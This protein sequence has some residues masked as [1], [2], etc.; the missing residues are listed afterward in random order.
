[1]KIWLTE[2]GEPLPIDVGSRPMRCGVL[3]QTLAAREHDVTWWAS[4]F[5][6]VR[7][8][9]RRPAA[10]T[11]SAGSRLHLELL[12]GPAYRRNVSVARIRHQRAMAHQF[13]ARAEALSPPD[14]LYCCVPTLEVTEAALRYA[15]PRGIPVV[16]DVRDMWP[17]IFVATLSRPLRAPARLLLHSEFG[18]ARRIFRSAAAILAVSEGY[19]EWAL[20]YAARPRRS[21]DAVFPH[22]YPRTSVDA[23]TAARARGQLQSLGVDGRRVICAFVGTF[24]L[25]YDLGTVIEAARLLQRTGYDDVQFVLAG[26]GER[27]PDW[28]AQAAGLSNVIFTG[29]IS[30]EAIAALLGMARF[31]LAAYAA[32]APQ[33]LPNKLG[34]YLSAGIPVLSSLRGETQHLLHEAGCGAS[35][36]AGDAPTL[37][38]LLKQLTANETARAEMGRRALERYNAEFSAQQVYGRLADH[39]EHFSSVAR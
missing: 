23:A 28:Q 2:I 31:G 8:T 37:A 10:E 30:A 27:R 7:K 33:G 5:D 4:T 21:S 20:R 35:Y 17:D 26:E 12:H 1:M 25:T 34:E 9:Y 39:L 22:A 18:R 36:P 16:V 6:H 13:T 32:D 29:W 19:L 15:R 3:A 38:A 24:G 11:V 14:L